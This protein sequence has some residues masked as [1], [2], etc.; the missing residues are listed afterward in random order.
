MRPLFVSPLPS[1]VGRSRAGGI[2]FKPRVQVIVIKLL[3]PQHSRIGLPHHLPR[4][5]REILADMRIVEFVRL[6]DAIAEHAIESLRKVV[7]AWCALRNPSLSGRGT[8]AQAR[9]IF[10]H[11]AERIDVRQAELDGPALTRAE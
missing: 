11:P 2:S 10:V 6:P 4:V 5:R 1:L 7:R 3:G 9:E 8:R